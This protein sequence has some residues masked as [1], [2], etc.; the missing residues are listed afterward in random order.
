VLRV[1]LPPDDEGWKRVLVMALDVT[2]RNRAQA[3]FAQAQAELTHVAR[4]TTL[5]ASSPPRSRMRS[6]SRCRRSSPMPS[7]ASAGWRAKRRARSKYPTASIISPPMAPAPPSVIARVSA[8]SRRKAD[9][10]LEAAIELA[11]LIEETIVAARPRSPVE[12]ASRSACRSCLTDVRRS[13]GDAVQIQ[14]VLMNLMLNAEQAMA[15]RRW[16]SREICTRRGVRTGRCRRCGRGARLRPRHRDDPER[17][18]P[19]L[20]HHQIRPAWAWACRSAARSS[21]SMAAR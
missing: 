15:E 18:V 3:R 13:T 1:T 9:P 5:G 14:Q 19:A 17:A 10:N 6:T 8:T 4:V 20:L 2:E 12:P 7:R 16:K 21:S 11:P